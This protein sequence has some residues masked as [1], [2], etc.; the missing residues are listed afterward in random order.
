ML[1]VTAFFASMLSQYAQGGRIAYV[2]VK[3]DKAS[4][5]EGENISFKLV[6]LASDVFFK[7]TGIA[8]TDGNYY[9]DPVGAIHIVRI[10]DDIDPDQIIGDRN[11]LDK[12]NS[13]DGRGMGVSFDYFNST[14]GAMSLSWNCT[15]MTFT[16]QDQFTPPSITYHK[17]LGGNYLIYPTIMPLAGHTVK[18]Q[19]D[20]NAIFH[21]DTLELSAVPGLSG[22][23]LTYNMTVSA[24]A[25]LA[26][27]SHC[28]MSWSTNGMTGQEGNG[29]GSN[30]VEF[31]IA[32]GGSHIFTVQ[33]QVYVYAGMQSFQ[34]T[35]WIATSW[36]NYSFEKTDW[37]NDGRWY[38][39]P[40]Y[41]SNY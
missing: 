19:L 8:G 12:V 25:S 20:R 36:G 22:T 4:Y 15:V 13:W 11:M 14:D 39:S 2:S 23:M 37:Y 16:Y 21:L 24:P 29:S 34:L 30:K 9:G 5:V 10:P 3:T 41:Y 35:G 38:D 26:G 40:Q 7:G 1:V 17:A 18:F 27:D 33:Q 32:S 28:T 6:P 31:D